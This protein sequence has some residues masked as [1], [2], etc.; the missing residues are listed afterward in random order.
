MIFFLRRACPVAA[1]I[2]FLGGLWLW[3]G[4]TYFDGQ[5]RLK[6]SHDHP[7]MNIFG[8]YFFLKCTFSAMVLL[9]LSRW[10]LLKLSP[11]R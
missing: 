8:L 10:L 7:F 11:P 1:A 6:T 3:L 2:I 5:V 4:S 9:I